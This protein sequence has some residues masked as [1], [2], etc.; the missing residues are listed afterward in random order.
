MKISPTTSYYIRKLLRSHADRLRS[1][2]APGAAIQA[3]SLSDLNAVV[4][5]LYLE[6]EELM[7]VTREIEDLV[8]LHSRLGS[9]AG[10]FSLYDGKLAELEQRIFWLLGLKQTVAG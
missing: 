3:D 7:R 6:E 2:F 8:Q 9:Q 5:S 4:A 1:V 10:R